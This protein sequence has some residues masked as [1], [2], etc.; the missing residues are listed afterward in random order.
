MLSS[1][2]KSL[3]HRRIEVLCWAWPLSPPPP[4]PPPPSVSRQ[5][6]LPGQWE[7][8][9]HFRCQG[10]VYLTLTVLASQDSKYGVVESITVPV[11]EFFLRPAAM[12]YLHS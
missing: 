11:L 2:T 5:R 7:P 1:Y 10:L 9:L 4:I 12:S 8:L 3:K 6:E